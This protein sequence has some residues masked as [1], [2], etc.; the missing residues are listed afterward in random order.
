M[1][2]PARVIDYVEEGTTWLREVQ[3]EA[4]ELPEPY[5]VDL[6]R[7]ADPPFKVWTTLA[8]EEIA[9]IEQ[10]IDQASIED[11]VLGACVVVTAALVVLVFLF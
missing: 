10:A 5:L 6:S 7:V 9:Q 3:A 11:Q 2:E 8:L 1:G 4:E